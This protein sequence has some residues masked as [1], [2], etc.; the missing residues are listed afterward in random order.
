MEHRSSD[1]GRD[2]KP[3][4]CKQ[5]ES[6]KH[7]VFFMLTELQASGLNT[8]PQH[9]RGWWEGPTF[10]NTSLQQQVASGPSEPTLPPEQLLPVCSRLINTAQNPSW[11]WSRPTDT[12]IK[13][14]HLTWRE[15]FST[16][17]FRIK[18]RTRC[19]MTTSCLSLQVSG[20]LTALM[21]SGWNKVSSSC[22]L[23]WIIS[24]WARWKW[25]V[26]ISAPTDTNW[27]DTMWTT[28]PLNRCLLL[29]T[30]HLASPV[31]RLMPEVSLESLVL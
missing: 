7:T 11:V 24:F 26:L 30:V 21:T 12:N 6:N 23:W 8:A 13:S 9:S 19:V 31:W 17:L 1:V 15:S 10:P 28:H 16:R 20:W 4:D 27:R 5:T 29:H 22:S 18:V 25:F 14:T 3:G 2:V